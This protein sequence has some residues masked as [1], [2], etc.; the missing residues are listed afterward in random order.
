MIQDS[1]EQTLAIKVEGITWLE[2][3]SDGE[4][5]LLVTDSDGG[6]SEVLNYYL[7]TLFLPILQVSSYFLA[8]HS[9]L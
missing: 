2:S 4:V 8:Y 6:D 5:F 9:T 7:V 3:T 1:K